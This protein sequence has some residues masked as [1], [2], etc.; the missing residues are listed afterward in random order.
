MD[1]GLK[2]KRALITGGS[3]GIG[4]ATT[5]ALLKK[6]CDVIVCSRNPT[7]VQGKLQHFWADEGE[8]FYLIC[9]VLQ[10]GGIERAMKAIEQEF[11]S[12]HI[13]INNVGGG[14]RWGTEQ[15]EESD[16][17]VWAD[18]Y[19]KNAGAAI[20]FTILALSM[21]RRQNWGR[22]V[23]VASL[24][25]REGG[26]RPW[27]AMAK[28][29]EIA[30]MKSLAGMKDLAR[31]NITFNSVAPGPIMIPDTGWAEMEREQPEAFKEYVDGLPLGRLGT[32]VEVA[33]VITFLCSERASLI[34]GACIA[35]D[36]GQGRA[37]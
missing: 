14:G 29:A 19:L 18:V 11:D 7:S 33:S 25:G 10:T 6:G 32:P 21:M 31:A 37:F 1:F 8:P 26:G 12:F 28:S 35:I 22:V 36:G 24:H 34:N 2:G 15:P 17:D 27:F 20:K 9:D 30:L 16:A 23:T 3:H 4:L 5:R 13:L